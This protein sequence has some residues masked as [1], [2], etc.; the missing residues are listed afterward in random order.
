MRDKQKRAKDPKL[1]CSRQLFLFLF[2]DDMPRKIDE[3]RIS[4][5]S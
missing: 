3:Q 2:L 5:L 4:T 1:Y